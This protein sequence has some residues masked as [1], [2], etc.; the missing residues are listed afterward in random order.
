MSG[1][2]IRK[3]HKHYKDQ[4]VLDDISM[5]LKADRSIG[6]LGENGAGK[7]TL[8]KCILKL[9]LPDGG[10]IITDMS[11]SEI[12]YLPELSYL[13]ES[14]TGMAMVRFAASFSNNKDEAAAFL[15]RVG[16]RKE[17]WNKPIRTYSKGMRQRTAIAMALIRRPH[18]LILDEPMSGLDA[19]GRRQMLEIFLEERQR[20]CS[21]LMS[22]HQVADIV[23]LCDEVIILSGGIKRDSVTIRERSVD[24]IDSLE[25]K[26]AHYAGSAE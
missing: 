22:S 25:Q 16:L 26:L 14:V 13:P 24:E 2:E 10:E 3:L 20:G 18:W 7:S 12:A 9:A 4:L 1:I 8:I 15:A 6:I 11:S 5:H 17:A 21:I 19:I 23:R